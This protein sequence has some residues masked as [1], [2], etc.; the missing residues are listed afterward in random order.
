MA[1]KSMND[2]ADDT[3]T[4]SYQLNR[5][6]EDIYKVLDVLLS[7]AADL[8]GNPVLIGI[9]NMTLD[10]WRDRLSESGMRIEF[11]LND[12]GVSY[13]ISDDN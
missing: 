4:D 2:Y 6:N 9:I 10:I 13:E 3:I 11:F 5:F 7:S 12:D 1:T 8:Q